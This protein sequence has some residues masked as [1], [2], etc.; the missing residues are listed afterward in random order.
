MFI[1]NEKKQDNILPQK[2]KTYIIET[3]KIYGKIK[4]NQ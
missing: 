1:K 3:N 4:S 2:Q